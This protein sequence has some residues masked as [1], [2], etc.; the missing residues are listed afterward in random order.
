M[1]VRGQFHLSRG[2]RISLLAGQRCVRRHHDRRRPRHPPRSRCEGAAPRQRN[3]GDDLGNPRV[4]ARAD[5]ADRH[6]GQC[7]QPR[8]SPHPDGLHRHQ[9]LYARR[10]ARGRIARRRLFTSGA[11]TRSARQIPYV[12][13]KVSQ[14]LQ[15]AGFDPNSHSGKALAHILEDYPRDELFQV[16]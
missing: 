16:D 14:V 12:R 9:T 11:Y 3:G 7:L 2:A 8:P 13:H 6:Q 4:H 15:R 5:A 1:A 10:P